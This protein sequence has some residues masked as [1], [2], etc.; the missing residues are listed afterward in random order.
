MTPMIGPYRIGDP[1]GEGGMGVVYRAR[2]A[3]TGEV[4]ALKTVKV[5]AP[6]WLES[7][8][9]EIDALTRI[10][11]PGIVRIV[12]HGVHEGRPWY[13]MDLLEGETLRNFALRIWNPYRKPLFEVGTTGGVSATEGLSGPVSGTA[14]DRAI[15]S[16]PVSIPPFSGIA[17][18]A[19][20]ELPRVLRLMQRVCA[21]LGFLHG[22]GFVNRDLKPEN[23]VLVRERPVIVDFGLTAQHPGGS[24]REALEAQVSAGTLQ[25]MSPEHLR[26]ELVDARSDLYAV[27]C[28]LYELVTGR[29]PFIGAPLAIKTQQLSS[30][31]IPPSELV[32]DV[33]PELDRLILRLLEKDLASRFGYGDEVAAALAEVSE[34]V[35]VLSSLPETR[36]H[37]Y[38]PRFVGRERIV[39]RLIEMQ[40]RAAAGSGALVLLGGESG[41]GKTRVAME[42][43]RIAPSA[44]IRVV[45]SE[46]SQLS[47]GAAG[48][49]GAEPL[50]ALRPLLRAI[51]DLCQEGGPETTDR[52]L[53]ERRSLLAVYEPLLWQVPSRGTPTPTA[54]MSAAAARPRLFA[55]LAETMAQLA[56]ERPVLW[57]ID[58]LGWADELSLDFLTTLTPGYLESTPIFILGTYRSEEATDGV[59]RLAALAHVS[60]LVLPRLSGD[61][62]SSM[63]HDM[64]A[65]SEPQAG[66]VEFVARQSEG[67]PFFVAEHVRT[68]V[69]EGMLKRN[70]RYSWVLGRD[71]ED[72]PLYEALPLPG[73][74]RDLIDR[75]LGK[76]TDTARR[77]GLAAAV[78]GR[79]V[80]LEALPD[81]AKVSAEEARTAVDELIRR[82]VLEQSEAG[83]VRFA[84]DKLREVSYAQASATERLDLHA[85][86]ALAL[87]GLWREQAEPSRF[88]AKLG[89]HF[90][91]GS[92]PDAAARYLKLA[93]THAKATYA[94]GDAI[95][96]YREAITQLRRIDAERGDGPSA[97]HATFV[98]LH[99]ALADTLAL[100][101]RRDEARAA[102]EEALTRTR[103]D[104]PTSRAR[105]HRKTGKTWE[106]EHR[107]TD[108]LSSYER[109]LETLPRGPEAP[110]PSYRDEWIQVHLDELWVY[111]FLDRVPE[112]E[113]LFRR[114][115]PVVRD[116][117]SP[118]QRARFLRTQWMRNLRRDRYVA[119]DDT[120][121]LARAALLASHQA[122]ENEQIL[123]DQF[124]L[125]F[126]L[127]FR[128]RL[129]EAS[130]ELQR[131]QSMAERAGDLARQ[132][133]CLTYLA[134]SERMRGRVD[135]AAAY[136]HH[137]AEASAKVGMIECTGAAQANAAWL[138]LKRGDYGA[139]RRHGREALTTW[140]G[141]AQRSMTVYPLQ[142]M[143]LV[144]LME[145]ALAEESLPEAVS[146]ATP[147]VA[148]SQ[149]HLPADAHDALTQAD[150][151]WAHG[152]PAGAQ[153]DLERA[154]FHLSQT[155]HH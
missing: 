57:V 62:V 21:A 135:E 95:R 37:L 48:G 66:F 59:L 152:N 102:Y 130:S 16:G 128:G 9:R 149:Q 142:W 73:S 29:A 137:A 129:D 107:H 19:A 140:E 54:A 99:E 118:V 125:G 71:R 65:L 63:V 132:T 77:V 24:S 101:G 110:S 70:P 148:P 64:L 27:G 88:W 139:A 72:R 123:L 17:P 8:R 46:L 15:E 56:R 145:A 90:A 136:A 122:D 86:A 6:R 78:I 53:G 154:L 120:L 18:A 113:T 91:L 34:D 94:N 103:E 20:G 150:E 68:A 39:E 51:A 114:L 127:L 12:D 83:W 106:T 55:Y 100:A 155:G 75:R 50:H 108:A 84:H 49:L 85:R 133:R 52:L 3:D 32:S 30:S 151:D 28:I 23:I 98:D 112:M 42:V 76:L 36:P 31:P 143:A 92:L 146:C 35:Q 153:A 96:L 74:L 43:T 40:E 104:K 22:E 111:Y 119:D 147:L 41:V 38:R 131:A 89:H 138:S 93:A 126:V 11:H 14:R 58:D 109:A 26:G 13:A 82:H 87:E 115:E 121:A 80:E 47:V 44:R 144:P 105:L 25:Y 81:V 4:V 124:G 117:A 60:H 97:N 79:D 2:H 67:N 141:L 1:L 116:H 7:I 134:L 69:N 45:T 33:P 61:A 5:T 10:S